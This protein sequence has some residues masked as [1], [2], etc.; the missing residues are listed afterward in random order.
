MAKSKTTKTSAVRSKSTP[1]KKSKTIA[2]KSKLVSKKIMPKPLPRKIKSKSLPKKTA[3]KSLTK[4]PTPK[5][6]KPKKP[7]SSSNFDIVIVEDDIHYDPKREAE[8]RR[9]YLEEARSQDAFD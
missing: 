2:R 7:S 4:K 1:A 3:L 9:A 5:K 6:S 8:E